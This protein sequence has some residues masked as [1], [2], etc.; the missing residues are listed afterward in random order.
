MSFLKTDKDFTLQ[1]NS[2]WQNLHITKEPKKAI[3]AYPRSTID[4]KDVNTFANSDR[5][6]QATQMYPR[7]TNIMTDVQYNN[8]DGNQ[9]SYPSQQLEA[10]RFPIQSGKDFLPLSRIPIATQKTRVSSSKSDVNRI[11][12]N[13]NVLDEHT[14]KEDITNIEYKNSKVKE[15]MGDFKKTIEINNPKINRNVLLYNAL[16]NKKG[17]SKNKKPLVVQTSLQEDRIE[18][19]ASS[20]KSREHELRNSEIGDSMISHTT[21]INFDG[22]KMINI[23]NNQIDDVAKQMKNTS[24]IDFSAQ[25]HFINDSHS[26]NA[27]KE[28]VLDDQKVYLDISANKIYEGNDRELVD[29][30][31]QHLESPQ[32]ISFQSNKILSKENV[33]YLN[34]IK[35]KDTTSINYLTTKSFCNKDNI[36]LVQNQNLES[37]KILT[38]VQSAK[39]SV[40]LTDF[41]AV[42]DTSYDL[43]ETI[44]AGSFEPKPQGK[45]IPQKNLTYR[46]V[47]RGETISKNLKNFQ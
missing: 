41:D 8:T 31:L 47:L 40:N 15:S 30:N 10:I 16:S 3:I 26:H 23:D 35:E 38:K 11:F 45:P 44:K 33:T 12:S 7:N 36:E 27:L 43:K 32:H 42:N 14:I 5:F 1:N 4:L 37:N 28:G 20:V 2:S 18:T 13:S 22:H 29:H 6:E 25:K 17:F 39:N 46:S 34:D 9:Q 19:K 24:N 21:N